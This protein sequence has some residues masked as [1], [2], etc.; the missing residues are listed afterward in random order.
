[1]NEDDNYKKI[2]RNLRN[3]QYEKLQI[4][5]DTA[6]FFQG[7]KGERSSVRSAKNNN[8]RDK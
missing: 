8:N 2:I 1:M 4:N 5:K 3:K 7:E 6:L